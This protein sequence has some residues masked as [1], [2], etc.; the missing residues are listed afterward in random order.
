MSEEKRKPRKC[1]LE[2]RS[3]TYLPSIIISEFLFW[4]CCP[5]QEKKKKT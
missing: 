4:E 5:F 2:V 3:L 1:T